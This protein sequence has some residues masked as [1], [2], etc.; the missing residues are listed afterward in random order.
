[1]VKT[2]RIRPLTSVCYRQ[3]GGGRGGGPDLLPSEVEHG[4]VATPDVPPVATPRG[5]VLQVA[6]QGAEVFRIS[7]RRRDNSHCDMEPKCSGSPTGDVTTL[8][9][10]WNR[11]VPDLQR[12]T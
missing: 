12:L 9:V 11:S 6:V 1:M 7:N 10:T 4:E 2:V 8:T 3:V 5:H